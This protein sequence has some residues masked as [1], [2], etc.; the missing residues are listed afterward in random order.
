MNTSYLGKHESAC[1]I[2]LEHCYYVIKNLLGP[3]LVVVLEREP[4]AWITVRV[5]QSKDQ[6]RWTEEEKKKYEENYF[7]Q[8]VLYIYITLFVI[9]KY[10]YIIYSDWREPIEVHSQRNK[11]VSINQLMN[12]FQSLAPSHGTDRRR[13]NHQPSSGSD[14]RRLHFEDVIPKA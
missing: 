5:L 10:I 3:H 7:T 9:R 1:W 12:L 2:P 13:N 8:N 6:K 11:I 14:P 4:P